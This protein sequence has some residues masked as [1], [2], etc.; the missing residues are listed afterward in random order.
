MSV[1]AESP[2]E[3]A[4]QGL[5]WEE[6]EA[7]GLGRDKLSYSPKWHESLGGLLSGTEVPERQSLP[8]K[9]P[10]SGEEELAL[11]GEG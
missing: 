10:G 1:E 5:P 9:A 7:A 6:A 11:A 3:A 4:G 8:Q 2:W